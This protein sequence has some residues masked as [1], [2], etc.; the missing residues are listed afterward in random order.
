MAVR[1]IRKMVVWAF[2]VLGLLAL[3]QAGPAPRPA[4]AQQINRATVAQRFIDAYNAGDVEG[5]LSMFADNA[6]YIGTLP[7]GPCTIMS[8]CADRDTLRQQLAAGI[9]THS[10]Y[11]VNALDVNGSNVVLQA[12]IRADVIRADGIERVKVA[13]FATVV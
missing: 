8:P 6:V 2:A 5:A 10:C 9:A 11:T 4:S 3:L 13:L 12:E 1:H 7:G